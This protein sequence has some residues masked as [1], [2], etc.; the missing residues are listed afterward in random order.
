MKTLVSAAVF[1]ASISMSAHS[2]EI[3]D[4]T[5][6]YITGSRSPEYSVDTAASIHVISNEEIKR[7]GAISVTDILRGQHGIHINDLYGDSSR[8]TIDMRGFGDRAVSNVIV[9]IDGIKLN[10]AIDA[11]TISYNQIPLDQIEQIEIVH[12]S[13]GVL[14][15]NQAVGGVINIITNKKTK[16]KTS[17]STSFGSYNASK[18]T[19]NINQQLDEKTDVNLYLSQSNSNGYRDNNESSSKNFVFGSN[20]K[21]NNGSLKASVQHFEENV[22]NPGSL[23]LDQLWANRIQSINDYR[24][25]FTKTI[26][27]VFTFSANQNLA[28]NW[29][30]NSDLSYRLDDVKFRLS[31]QKDCFGCTSGYRTK[32]D[33]QDREILTLNPRVNGNINTSIGRI[34]ITAGADLQYSDYFI[35]AVVAQQGYQSIAALYGQALLPISDNEDLSLGLRHARVYNDIS[36]DLPGYPSHFSNAILNL[37]DHVNVGSIGYTYSPS[38]ELRLFSRIDQNYR[39]AT[40]EEHTLDPSTGAPTWGDPTGLKN[41]TGTSY[42]MGFEISNS[43]EK[44]MA[45][46]YKLDLKNEIS[47]DSAN[48]YNINIDKSSRLGFNVSFSKQLNN[49]ITLSFDADVMKAEITGGP[50]KGNQIPLVPEKQIRTALNWSPTKNSSIGLSALYLS[51][52]VLGSDY[53]N[54][55]R[56]LKSFTAL[57]LESSYVL[58]SWQLTGRVNNLLN[59]QYSE[60]G[61][62]GSADKNSGFTECIVGTYSDTCPAYTPSPERNFWVGATYTFE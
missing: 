48:G 34:K 46:V 56:K 28:E 27:N 36:H 39:F 32:I 20:T 37:D 17:L 3:D 29:E 53:Q 60:Y 41:Q 9:M 30:F 58:N 5:T 23:Y 13:S 10:S 6:I 2:S 21:I 54:Q 35:N 49:S 57:N 4:I 19:A 16:Q 26:S 51:D 33:T 52:Q 47:Y 62:A 45:Q 61:V 15:G 22:A 8:A 25:D 1:A 12:G 38:N 18:V 7:S 40:L 42:E 43:L 14:F 55:F 44:F 59:K 11:P 31:S 50:F 24:D